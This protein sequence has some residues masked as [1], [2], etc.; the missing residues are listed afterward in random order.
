DTVIAT[1]TDDD[2]L[3]KRVARSGVGD[4]LMTKLADISEEA[5]Y[6][7]LADFARSVG[8]GRR[9]DELCWLLPDAAVR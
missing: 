8:A 3:A 2:A 6:D 5:N 9:A 4:K 7:A 1:D